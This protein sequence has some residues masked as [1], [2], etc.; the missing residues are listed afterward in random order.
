MSLD[1]P[2]LLD[3]A[4]TMISH[5]PHKIPP[6]LAKPAPIRFY[7]AVGALLLGILACNVPTGTDTATF[8]PD[9][10]PA[11]D[12]ASGTPDAGT[13]PP[14]ET[15]EPLDPLTILDTYPSLAAVRQRLDEMTFTSTVDSQTLLTGRQFLELILAERKYNPQDNNQVKLE[16]FAEF[17][18]YTWP[19]PGAKIYLIN[20]ATGLIAEANRLYPW[21]LQ[22]Y[23]PQEIENLFIEDDSLRIE[24]SGVKRGV[25][26]PGMP[27]ALFHWYPSPDDVVADAHFKQYT[28]AYRLV[29]GE[30]TQEEAAA[31]IVVWM[32]QNFF[33]AYAPGYDWN[34]YLDGREPRTD[35]G[36]VA[37][38]LSIE[39]IY[40][41]RVAGCH[42]PTILMEGMFHSL[43]IP[44]V[45]LTMHGHGVLYLPTLD[46]YIH[47]DHVV[48]Y[49]DAP[50][51]MLLLTA[52]E[53]L[54]FAE[55]KDWIYAIVYPDKYSSPLISM[56]MY[57]EAGSLYF[58]AEN[59]RDYT[60]GTCVQVSDEDWARVSQQLSVYN[61]RY[62]AQTCMLNSDRIPILT[63][64]E[65]TSPAP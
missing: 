56:P 53:I 16:L 50:A 15:L 47:G 18:R 19:H 14:S 42:E 49:H 34:V 26:P 10:P 20:V 24:S 17:D 54:P 27:N 44:A 39:R 40:E 30:T 62:D 63:L 58:Y 29:Q 37:Y 9:A 61:L 12:A 1:V 43:N 35:G 2:V 60:A 13:P 45:R 52:E 21:S 65:L 51:G 11:I 3:E 59:V 4:Q 48:T 33:H 36:A 46:R 31:S 55:D 28:L 23:S 38:P 22:D 25:L 32:Q 41:E 8:S 57:R 6:L 7:H 64:D 5:D